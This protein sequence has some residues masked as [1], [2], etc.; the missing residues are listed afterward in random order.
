VPRQCLWR[1]SVTLISTLLLTYLL[2]VYHKY[3]TS[4]TR[5]SQEYLTAKRSWSAFCPTL[6]LSTQRSKIVDNSFWASHSVYN[7]W[8]HRRWDDALSIGN[9]CDLTP[10]LNRILINICTYFVFVFLYVIFCICSFQRQLGRLVTVSDP[11]TATNSLSN[12]QSGAI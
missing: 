6:A 10:K 4:S 12:S 9:S 8:Q 1:D 5:I 11:L 3:Y 2:T 7:S